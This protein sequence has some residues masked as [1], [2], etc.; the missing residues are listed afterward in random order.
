MPRL[1]PQPHGSF[2]KPHQYLRSNGRPTTREHEDKQHACGDDRSCRTKASIHAPAALVKPSARL[3]IFRR[4]I[5]LAP[6]KQ[7][8]GAD[9]YRFA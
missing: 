2:A 6:N 4:T 8:K 1:C 5:T 9:A 7:P 3:P